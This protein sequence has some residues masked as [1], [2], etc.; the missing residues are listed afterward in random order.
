MDKITC[1]Q[2]RGCAD[3]EKCLSHHSILGSL[4]LDV[5]KHSICSASDEKV[6]VVNPTL[7][8]SEGPLTGNQLSSFTDGSWPAPTPSASHLTGSPPLSEPIPR[9]KR[10]KI[11]NLPAAHPLNE[12]LRR[13]N[14]RQNIL[15]L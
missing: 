10:L 2:Q 12:H 11:I 14:N 4:D 7:Y 1:A 6:I 3:N 8:P 9:D 5:P 13:Q 15:V